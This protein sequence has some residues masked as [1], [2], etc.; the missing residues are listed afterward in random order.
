MP[1]L[2][3]IKL[4]A[5]ARPERADEHSAQQASHGRRATPRSVCCPQK[6]QRIHSRAAA[7]LKGHY[8]ASAPSTTDEGFWCFDKHEN[9]CERSRRAGKGVLQVL[10]RRRRTNE[11]ATCRSRTAEFDHGR[12]LG[13]FRRGTSNHHSKP[14]DGP[15]PVTSLGRRRLSGNQPVCRVHPTILH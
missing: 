4:C 11:I 14:R 2:D 15:H 1:S 13:W 6:Q 9:W 3:G 7:A 8:L 10:C 5:F 12:E